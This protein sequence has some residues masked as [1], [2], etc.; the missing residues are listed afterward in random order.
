MSRKA[1]T[2]RG[3]LPIVSQQTRLDVLHYFVGTAPQPVEL[4]DNSNLRHTHAC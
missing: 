3:L 1:A 4:M 2:R